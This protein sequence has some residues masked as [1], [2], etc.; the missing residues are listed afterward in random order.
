MHSNFLIQGPLSLGELLDRA[1]RLYR[2]RF[3]PFVLLAALF[4]IPYGIFSALV[5]GNA[6]VGYLNFL[7]NMM[8]ESASDVDVFSWSEFAPAMDFAGIMFSTS[9]VGLVV[10][11]I[12]TLGLVS[13]S[14]AALHGRSLVWS[15][16]LRAGLRRFWPYIGMVLLKYLALT[17][18]ALGIYLFFFLCLLAAFAVGGVGMA[19]V[20]VDGGEQSM[21][22]MIAATGLV[23]L[24][25]CFSL[26]LLLV[27]I[28]P[29]LYLW[30]RWLVTTPGLVEQQWGPVQSLRESWRLTQGQ[31]R[32]CIIYS[33]LLYI[34][35]L[36]VVSAPAYIVQQISM[37]LAPPAWMGRVM[38]ASVGMSALFNVLWQPFFV[39]A[40]VLLYYDLRVR[41]ESYDLELRIDRMETELIE[42]DG[43]RQSAT[44][45]ERPSPP[46]ANG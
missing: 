42:S 29:L 43:G 38:G 35:N 16:S 37:A 32:R 12:V 11:A 22:G 27:L 18:V 25:L 24:L 26:F 2:A 15:A 21:G 3:I 7:Q 41:R 30:A 6:T 45:T 39:A 23:L 4:W 13:Q 10:Q 20:N 34:L 28:M 46:P 19:A 1:F 31:V 33:V 9:L 17:L 5:T 40:L 8:V 44:W 36:V 14:T